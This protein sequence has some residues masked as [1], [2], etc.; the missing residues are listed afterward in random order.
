[1]SSEAQKEYRRAKKE[2]RK[3][4]EEWMRSKVEEERK[5]RRKAWTQVYREKIKANQDKR[6]TERA[7]V[8]SNPILQEERK[9]YRDAKKSSKE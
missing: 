2:E 7:Y 1:M 5:A 4:N 9:A 6:A 3:L 8:A